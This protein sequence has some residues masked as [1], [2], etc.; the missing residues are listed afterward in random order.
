MSDPFMGASGCP[1]RSFSIAPELLVKPPGGLQRGW[2]PESSQ[3]VISLDCQCRAA[4]RQDPTEHSP[5]PEPSTRTS[6]KTRMTAQDIAEALDDVE[7]LLGKLER[8]MSD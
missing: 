6:T 5:S 3:Y 1:G 8:I 7:A 4:S 2:T